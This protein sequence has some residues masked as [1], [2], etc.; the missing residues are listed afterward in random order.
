MPWKWGLQ[1][2]ITQPSGFGLFPTGMYRSLTFYFAEAAATFARKPSNNLRLEGL[3]PCLSSCSAKT[4]CRSVHQTEDWRP[5]WSG[6]T[7]RSPDL[8]VAKTCERSVFSCGRSFTHHFP[9]VGEYPLVPCCSQVGHCPYF[10]SFSVGQVVSLTSPTANT[11]MLQ[12]KVWYLL[13]PFWFSPWEPCT[14][15]ASGHTH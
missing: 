2:V 3:H 9:W 7:R 15:A 12:L 8:R 6:F 10:S 13:A 5:W 14:L 4:S 1:V 11:W